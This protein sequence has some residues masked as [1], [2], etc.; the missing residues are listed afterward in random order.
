MS[1]ATKPA[2][3]VAP[4]ADATPK[5]PAIDWSAVTLAPVEATSVQPA[6]R[7]QPEQIPAPLRELVDALK[8]VPGKILAVVFPT[9]AHAKQAR[10]LINQ[11]ARM[12][13]VDPAPNTYLQPDK[14][15]LH[16]R[17]PVKKAAADA[18]DAAPAETPA[19]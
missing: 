15:T 6:L 18:A 19:A 3:A 11:Y 16:V 14:L 7:K 4:A 5:A 9:E 13:G 2:E 8:E 12:T 17:V 1:T 10:T